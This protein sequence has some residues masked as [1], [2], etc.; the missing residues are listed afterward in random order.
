MNFLSKNIICFLGL[1]LMYSCSKYDKSHHEFTT[2]IQDGYYLETY[3]V[4][5]QGA[6]GTDVYA[7]YLTDSNTFRLFIDTYDTENEAISFSVTED[8][9]ILI[10]YYFKKNR[11]KDIVYKKIFPIEELKLINKFE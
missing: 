6:F 5:S 3:N 8:T 9:I 4:F 10:K 11:E 2:K 7:K 1:L